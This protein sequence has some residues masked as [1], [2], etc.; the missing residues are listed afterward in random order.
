MRKLEVAL[1]AIPQIKNADFFA[2]LIPTRNS[3]A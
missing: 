2:D 3:N 1:P